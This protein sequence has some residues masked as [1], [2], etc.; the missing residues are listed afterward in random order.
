[1]DIVPLVLSDENRIKEMKK[2]KEYIEKYPIL[3]DIIGDIRQ[4]LSFYNCINVI[5]KTTNIGSSLLYF[6][7]CYVNK[8]KNQ[9]Y[10]F[11]A[12][13]TSEESVN[14]YTRI[15]KMIYYLYDMKVDTIV[16]DLRGN[17]GGVLYSYISAILPLVDKF[18]INISI[19]NKPGFIRIKD[20]HF[21][22]MGTNSV[23]ANVVLP[24]YKKVKFKHIKVIINNKTASGGEFMTF[25][26]KKYAGA[27]TYGETSYG[28]L[29]TM[30]KLMYREF[31][32]LYPHGEI[33]DP[34]IKHNRLYPDIEGIPESIYP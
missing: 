20:D 32:I 21:Q 16:F 9:G 7:Q 1:M 22:W 23:I 12:N 5:N 8:E 24:V 2:I 13:T 10:I 17:Y 3:K 29:N 14:F 26:L 19:N 11:C 30:N 15:N 27:V 33:K 25:L 4:Y 28:A 31:M 18:N 6:S 34:L